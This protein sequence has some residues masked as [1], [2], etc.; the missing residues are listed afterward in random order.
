MIIFDRVLGA[1]DELPDAEPCRHAPQVVDHWP[2]VGPI[3]A[4]LLLKDLEGAVGNHVED[5]AAAIPMWLGACLAGRG[6]L[7]CEEVRPQA[8]GIA[9]S[10]DILLG[11]EEHEVDPDGPRQPAHGRGELHEHGHAAAAVVH[12]EEHAARFDRIAIGKRPRVVVGAEQHPVGTVGMPLH[13]QVFHR[14][15]LAGPPIANLEGLSRHSRSGRLKV[16]HDEIPLF[17]HAG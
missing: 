10:D 3:H 17:R 14:Y 7:P 5:D 2:R 12:A 11:V 4:V 15:R 13:D 6:V 9:R 16:G 8:V 1:R